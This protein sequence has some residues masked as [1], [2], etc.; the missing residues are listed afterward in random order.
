MK[1]YVCNDCGAS[2]TAETKNTVTIKNAFNKPVKAHYCYKCTEV[3]WPELKSLASW[4]K[5][6]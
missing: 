3:R 2:L 1:N 4:T 5:P 6:R